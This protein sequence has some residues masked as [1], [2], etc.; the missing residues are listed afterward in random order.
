MAN[1]LTSGQTQEVQQELDFEEANVEELKGKQVITGKP[2]F[3][4]LTEA[5]IIDA[6]LMQSKEWI[7][8]DKTK[9]K[10]KPAHVRVRFKTDINGA[11]VE[12]TD[13]FGTLKIYESGKLYAGPQSGI[14][15]LIK[16][17]SENFEYDGDITTLCGWI[18]EQQV[19][20]I[21]ESIKIGDKEYK[22]TIIRQFL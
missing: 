19:K 15:R 17:V 12:W 7:I 22:K 5:E 21:T 10:C 8:D 2:E 9:E 20:V 3:I 18:E 16:V 14:G 6:K 4:K 13:T 1:E 11:P